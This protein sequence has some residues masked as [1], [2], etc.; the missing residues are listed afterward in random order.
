MGTKNITTP[1]LIRAGGLRE[2]LR[3]EGPCV[4]VLLPPYRPGEQSGSQAA[5][6]RS[7]IP[8]ASR[9][10]T[11][12]GYAKSSAAALLAPLDRLLDDPALASGSRWSRA[13]FCSPSV[14]ELVQLTQPFD[15][16][17]TVGGSFAIRKMAAELS[18]PPAFYILALSRNDVELLRCAGLHAEKVKLPPGVP[19]TLD[20]AMAFDAPDHDLENRSEA[21]TTVGNMQGVRFGT[22]SARE[23]VRT[24]LGDF[25][26]VVDRGVQEVVR[27]S[28]IPLLLAG[29]EEDAAVYRSV[30]TSRNLLTQGITGSPALDREMEEILHRAY[31]VLRAEEIE[32]Q[33]SAML[34][35]RERTAP[36]RFSTELAPV[37]RAAFEGRVHQLYLNADASRQEV[38]ERGTYRSWGPEDLLN[39]AGVQTMV[40]HGKVCELPARMMPDGAEAAALMRF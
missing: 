40:H 1:E 18:R 16:S 11:G 39:L 9:Q 27:Q 13:A 2:M 34:E 32:R 8:E 20:E 5:L 23:R 31:D 12:R 30:S 28:D 24:Y 17:L 19:T 25:Y 37:L 4:T 38:Y 10:L 26:R 29:V 21:G 22:G 7:M 36:S 15:G 33:A 14:F 35:A 3:S 6:L